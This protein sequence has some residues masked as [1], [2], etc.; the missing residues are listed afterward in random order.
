[1]FGDIFNVNGDFIYTYIVILYWMCIWHCTIS[2]HSV[3]SLEKYK[4]IFRPD[5]KKYKQKIENC[6]G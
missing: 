2:C 4:N 1:M 6:A 5:S 3:N